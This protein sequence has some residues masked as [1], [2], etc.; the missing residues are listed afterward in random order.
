MGSSRS[1]SRGGLPISMRRARRF[2]SVAREALIGKV[3][4]EALPE[5]AGSRFA[6]EYRRALREQ[7]PVRFEE[8]YAPMGRTFEARAYPVTDGLAVYFTDV[9][10][11]RA[12][13]ERLRQGQRLAAI[14]DVT[15][16][17]AHDFDD[18]LTAIGGFAGVGQS[19]VGDDATGPCL[20]QI[21]SASEQRRGLDAATAR[22]LARAGAPPQPPSTST[23][24][25]S[26]LVPRAASLVPAR[27]RASIVR[28]LRRRCPSCRP[29]P[30]RAGAAEPR[31]QQPRRDRNHRIDH[32]HH[33]DDEPRHLPRD[34]G[35]AV[36][37]AAGRRHGHRDPRG[38][39]C[40]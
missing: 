25:S 33:G 6:D 27:H 16:S 24:S 18:L 13:E 11:E 17:V 2:S 37:L 3:V 26:D 34:A 31:R 39:C 22:L 23:C 9:T 12:R 15:A 40:R 36:R 10:S 30:A 4:W 1:T 38:A 35:A 19:T 14:G 7:V 29:H 8:T 32:D 20:D 28:C 5:V 21:A